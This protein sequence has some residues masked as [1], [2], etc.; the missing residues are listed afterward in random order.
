MSARP[1][2]QIHTRS[3]RAS[4]V[5]ERL[6][7]LIDQLVSFPTVARNDVA[8]RNC[9][10]EV[11]AHAM[12]HIPCLH[13]QTFTSGGK[14]S[15]LFVCGDGPLRVLLAGHL[16]VVAADPDAFSLQR[17]RGGWL[18]G[19]GVADMKGP[20]AALLDLV[21][22]EPRPGLALL[23]TTDEESGGKDGVAHVLQRLDQRPEVVVL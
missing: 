9:L 6:A 5:T 2:E 8:L 23:L 18:G 21:E 20:I 7:A 15:I 19:R 11:R 10:A 14:H 22:A 16:D 13:V 3:V 1:I 17:L 4:A 12:S